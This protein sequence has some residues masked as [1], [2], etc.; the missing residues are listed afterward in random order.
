MSARQAGATDQEIAEAVAI[1][2]Q[3]RAMST[4]FYGTQVDIDR[5]RAEMGGN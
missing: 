3:T 4:I 1:A 5:F 2:A